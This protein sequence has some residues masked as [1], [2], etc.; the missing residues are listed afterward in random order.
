MRKISLLLCLIV[1]CFCMVACGNASENTSEAI[2]SISENLGESIP[3]SEIS[4]PA[5]D[6]LV[7]SVDNLQDSYDIKQTIQAQVETVPMIDELI[8]LIYQSSNPQVATFS[9]G[10]IHTLSEGETRLTVTTENGDIISNFIMIRVEDFKE[11]EL[12][13][14]IQNAETAINQ[15]QQVTLDKGSLIRE[16]RTIY[17]LLPDEAKKRVS[18]FDVLET[19]EKQFALLE[20]QSQKVSTPAP[21]P[22]DEPSDDIEIPPAEETPPVEEDQPQGSGTVYWTP[23][24][25]SYH[26]TSGCRSLAR[27]K[28]I[29]SGSIS[30]AKAAGKSDPCNNCIR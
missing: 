2:D 20:E 1:L 5:P 26:S 21:I 7:L 6:K 27:S 3:I 4:I 24:G 18:N 9:N 16:A 25:K 23:N 17:D 13:S 8:P 28:T 29:L 15:I 10:T 30:D 22:S 12:Q 19:A 14:Q 11:K